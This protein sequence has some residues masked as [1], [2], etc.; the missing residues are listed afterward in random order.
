VGAWLQAI[1]GTA[2]LVSLLIF[3]TL[4]TRR[5]GS[6][7]TPDNRLR[8]GMRYTVAIIMLGVLA[9]FFLSLSLSTAL[10]WSGSTRAVVLIPGLIIV[11][12]ISIVVGRK[13]KAGPAPSA[14]DGP[15]RSA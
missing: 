15:S 5:D 11:V 9:I 4:A 1:L 13:I 10:G 12:V 2:A 7:D 6:A 14:S 8:R 3:F